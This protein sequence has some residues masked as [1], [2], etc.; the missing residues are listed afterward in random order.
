L[1]IYLIAKNYGWEKFITSIFA[2]AATILI[3]IIPYNWDNPVTFLFNIYSTGYGGYQY[4][5]IN[6]FNT[7]AFFGFWK[8]DTQTFGFLNF[9][10]IGWILFACSAMFA[11]FVL[12]KRFK[13]SGEMRGIRKRAR[14]S[15]RTEYFREIFILLP[16]LAY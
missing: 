8:P 9:F 3:V 13:A 10:I 5:T 2:M 6:A 14:R 7:W 16:S 15:V 11:I 12:H 4:T 1:V